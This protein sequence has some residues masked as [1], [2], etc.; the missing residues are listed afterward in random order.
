MPAHT[1][2]RTPAASARLCSAFA[3]CAYSVSSQTSTYGTRAAMAASSTAH[4]GS[5]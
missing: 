1:S 3:R 2:A 4:D 5:R